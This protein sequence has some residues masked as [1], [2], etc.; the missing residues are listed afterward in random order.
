MQAA[1]VHIHLWGVT[2]GV[3]FRPH[4]KRLAD[5]LGLLGRVW[6]APDGVHVELLANQRVAE[7]WL[8]DLLEQP[9]RGAY[10][11]GY[12]LEVGHYPVSKVFSIEESQFGSAS[13]TLL[14]PDVAICPECR[15]ELQDPTNRRFAY[16]FITCTY[17]GPRYSIINAFPYDRVRTSMHA[18]EPCSSC[19]QE[20]LDPQNRRFHSQT[21]SCSECGP[22]LSLESEL[23]PDEQDAIQQV[24]AWLKAGRIGAV[25]GVAG[26]LLLCDATNAETIQRLRSRKQRPTKP[27][28]VMYPKLAAIGPELEVS[29]AAKEALLSAVAPIVLLPIQ[30]AV[31][32]PLALEALAP[33]LGEIGLMLPAAP[34]LQLISTACDR[35]LVATS[36]NISGSPILARA[37]E[38]KNNLSGVAD[39]FLHHDR[40][41]LLPQDDSVVRFSRNK[42]RPI[43]L[44]RARGLAPIY[45]TDCSGK[46]DGQSLLAFGSDLKH[47]FCIRQAGNTFI[48]PYLGDLSVYESQERAAA[49][50]LHLL[51]TSAGLP[52]QLIADAHPAYHSTALAQELSDREGLRLKTI[53]HHH[54]HFGA[55][56]AEHR[57]AEPAEDILGVIWDGTGYGI[58]G[59]IWGGEF[60]G[61]KNGEV[62]RRAH[63]K[64][65][66]QLIGDKMSREPRLSAL[67]LLVGNPL[68][69]RTLRPYFTE[70]EWKY[71][72]SLLAQ[73]TSLQTSSM[74]RLFDAVAALLGLADRSAFEGE[75]AMLL[76]QVARQHEQSQSP[77]P[78][79]DIPWPVD[80]LLDTTS[81]LGLLLE[82]HHTGQI[83]GLTALKFHRQC[84]GIIE[85]VARQQPY[86]RIAF[87]GGVW[88]N[89][90]LVDLADRYL[91]Q[92][93]QLLFHREL[94]PN[95]ENISYGQLALAK[96]QAL[97]PAELS[98]TSTIF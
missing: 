15:A 52:H 7:N 53:Q 18:F 92:D 67:S 56:L 16:P 35:P 22:R 95:D 85:A 54:A 82:E 79:M 74:G 17:C 20:Y 3:G 38:V 76:E 6:N 87:S 97:S 29:T 62:E 77:Y 86:T 32:S 59:Q 45:P 73:A 72:Q 49:C 81:W 24:A 90:L 1:G 42:Q 30:S 40:E 58:D 19:E 41:I 68:G 78:D 93:Y 69:E 13:T 88:Q 9:P 23:E 57:I 2:Q 8:N 71:Y 83:L 51:S 48:S 70:L 11:S 31:A 96:L 75:A 26:Y 65:F 10:I 46:S 91:C 66:P 28:A 61:W 25:K 36:A 34:L 63:L 43:W 37:E 89:S 98:T 33:G 39:F 80:N 60:L 84:I 44:R 5:R 47:S 14:P 4:L 27:L 50:L 55:V 64:Y 94:S 12:K 21:N